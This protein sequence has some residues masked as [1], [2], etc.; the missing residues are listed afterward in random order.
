MIYDLKGQL[1]IPE[2]IVE[3]TEA[4]EDIIKGRI[5]FIDRDFRKSADETEEVIIT[6]QAVLT[7]DQLDIQFQ[8]LLT[9]FV[10]L[11]H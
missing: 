11:K 3:F 7:F 2:D 6:L 1:L 5:L 4:V 8:E 9:S 10:S